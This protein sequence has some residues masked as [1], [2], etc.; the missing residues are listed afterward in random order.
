MPSEK[1][2][3]FEEFLNFGTVDST[4]RHLHNG[5]FFCREEIA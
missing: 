5:V 3:E 2:G 1:K 4:K